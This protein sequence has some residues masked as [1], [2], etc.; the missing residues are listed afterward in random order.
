MQH[1]RL[2]TLY[3][4]SSAIARLLSAQSRGALHQVVLDANLFGR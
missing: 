2:K 4:P 3:R 1:P